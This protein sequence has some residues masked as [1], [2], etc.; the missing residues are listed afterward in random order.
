MLQK[1][2]HK[3]LSIESRRWNQSQKKNIHIKNFDLCVAYRESFTFFVNFKFRY[4][5]L[6]VIAFMLLQIVDVY[7]QEKQ[8][9]YTVYASDSIQQDRLPFSLEA[10]RIY[11]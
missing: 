2:L 3:F 4:C 9:E 10:G 6:S 11:F 1:L 8:I 7:N 5:L